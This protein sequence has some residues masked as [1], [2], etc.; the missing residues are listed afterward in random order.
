MVSPYLHE[1]FDKDLQALFFAQS[2]N[3]DQNNKEFDFQ[4][5]YYGK[6]NAGNKYTK[7]RPE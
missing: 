6:H 5:I 3:P 4:E 1:I 7:G 2:K